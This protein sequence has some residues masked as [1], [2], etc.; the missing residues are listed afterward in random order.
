MVSFVLFFVFLT[1]NIF[2][3]HHVEATY[4]TSDIAHWG[5]SVSGEKNDPDY[6]KVQSLV[7][8]KNYN[9]ALALLDKKT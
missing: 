7:E 3:T 6:K 9:E 4:P 5:L 2:L 1:F 8:Q